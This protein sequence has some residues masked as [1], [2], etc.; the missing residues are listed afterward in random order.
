LNEIS[1]LLIPFIKDIEIWRKADRV[2]ESTVGN[3]L[4]VNIDLIIEKYH[5]MQI[6][7]VPG[8]K[9]LTGTEALIL[10]SLDEIDYDSNLP[11]VRIRFSLAHE[12][13]HK[14]LHGRLIES[15]KPPSF[16]EWEKLQ[17]ETPE[18]TRNRAEYQA[19]EFAGRLLVPK[20]DL[21]NE[22]KALS[23]LIKKAK[24]QA[25]DLS[26]DELNEFIAGRIC[27]KFEVSDQVISKRLQKEKINPFRL[28][29]Q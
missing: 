13:G 28:P 8:L 17:E 20:E 16:E 5:G 1:D 15:I 4:P 14:I 29:N 22:V 2:R 24:A 21:I 11:A 18:V 26:G 3:C 7:P 9:K 25:P 12:L 23:P 10:S 19:Y 6:V 27:R